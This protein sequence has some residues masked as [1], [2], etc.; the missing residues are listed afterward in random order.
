MNLVGIDFGK[1]KI[2]LALGSEETGFAEPLLVI[3]YQSAEEAVKKVMQVI[4]VQQV[5]KAVVGISE[6]KSEIQA[7]EFGELLQRGIKIEVVF[8]DETLTT[9]DAQRKAIE[10]GIGRKK[11]RGMEDAYAATIILQNYLDLT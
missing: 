9:A 6:G 5:E 2:G 7:R 4:Q 3:K 11:R 10:A 8:Q 1:R